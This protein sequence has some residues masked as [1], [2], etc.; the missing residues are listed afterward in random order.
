M[1]KVLLTTLAATL[2]VVLFSNTAF[3]KEVKTEKESDMSIQFTEDNPNIPD[4]DGPFA[5]KLSFPWH[6]KAFAFGKREAVLAGTTYDLD[7]AHAGKQYVV[8][9]DARRTTDADFGKTWKVMAKMSKLTEVQESGATT[10]PIV[11]D[12]AELSLTFGD[13]SKYT[14]GTEI[15][16]S[17]PT[18][19]LPSDPNGLV[20]VDGKMINSVEAYESGK[21]PGD[22][23]LLGQ[24]GNAI[25]G[26]VL[27]LKNDQ[28]DVEAEF[29]VLAQDKL[30]D[31]D[32]AGV[33]VNEGYATNIKK[34]SIK[35]ANL[36]A[37]VINKAFSGKVTW[38]F[39][40]DITE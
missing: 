34:A 37:E 19:I 35:F 39:T 36:D 7:N 12:N 17:K 32:A 40:T 10:D 1:K 20:E 27:T 14:L 4:P 26:E 23:S 3:A 24:T 30:R 28:A 33:R 6:P 16:P 18:E 29:P 21:A 2:G 15:N 22:L 8:V 31:K 5:N 38:T 13:V 25:T 11:I 9:N